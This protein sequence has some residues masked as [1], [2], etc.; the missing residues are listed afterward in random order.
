MQ[1]ILNME[2][3]VSSFLSVIIQ[4]GHLKKFS[5]SVPHVP[6]NL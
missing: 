5:L 1:E 2:E 4:F 6:E 3:E